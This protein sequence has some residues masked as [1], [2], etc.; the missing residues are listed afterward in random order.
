M[1]MAPHPAPRVQRP[2]SLPS[3]AQGCPTPHTGIQVS[4]Q[5]PVTPGRLLWPQV[6]MKMNGEASGSP[7][8]CSFGPKSGLRGTRCCFKQWVPRPSGHH[9]QPSGAPR[10]RTPPQS[11]PE[12]PATLG[13]SQPH[14][15]PPG[16]VWPRQAPPGPIGRLSA[17]RNIAR[18]L[19]SS[20]GPGPACPA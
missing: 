15:V 4:V 5:L 11:S 2:H 10:P 14:Q 6:T 18:K 13:A 19:N 12:P 7:R 3:S 17:W 9:W 8:S 16:T 1:L 20:P